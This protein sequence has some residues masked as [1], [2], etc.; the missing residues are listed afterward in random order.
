MDQNGMETLLAWAKAL[1]ICFVCVGPFY[2]VFMRG[3]LL[4][5]PVRAVFTELPRELW[6][7]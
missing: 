5:K 7:S 4:R 1:V 2:S 3:E 6:V